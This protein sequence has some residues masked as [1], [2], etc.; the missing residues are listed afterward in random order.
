[1]SADD[2]TI[3]LLQQLVES[4][5]D[6]WQARA[7]LIELHRARGDAQ[8]AYALVADIRPPADL[9]A[10]LLVADVVR[11]V[12]PIRAL[13]HYR[14]IIE[15]ERGCAPAHFALAELHR[16]ADRRE[17]ARHHYSLAVV[18]DAALEDPAFDA[19]LDGE[20]TPASGIPDIYRVEDE[21]DVSQADGDEPDGAGPD[22]E[23]YDDGYDDGEDE[24]D[25]PSSDELQEMID[26]RG[27]AAPRLP[28]IDFRAV[29]GMDEL[30]ERV[31]MH[32]IYP[33]QNPE[34]F[35]KF[36]KRP[37]GGIMLYGP[38]GCGK[39]YLARATAG[40]CNAKFISVT[41][42]D[43]LS[44]WLG[45]SEQRLS[46]IFETARRNAPA[47]IFIDELDALGMNRRD[48]RGSAL[49]TTINHFL[50]EMDGLHASNENLM[51][52]AA[53]N[54]PWSV[55][56]AFRRPGRFDR[57]VL[58]P[59][60]DAAAR[61]AILEIHLREI[62]HEAPDYD[63]LVKATRQFSGADLRAVVERAAEMAIMHEMKTGQP[64]QL[65]RKMLA[66]A[67]KSLKASTVEWLD[68]AKNYANYSNRAGQY[69]DLATY[70]ESKPD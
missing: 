62:P 57:V 12:D 56:P 50:T 55:D 13:E 41:V 69:D 16:S 67:V 54:A 66:K 25:A 53:T 52:L 18:I 23:G 28:K 15:S 11:A 8:A 38:P 30:K 40:E 64:A 6:N 4:Q 27:M 36:K 1:V 3:A 34:L 45:E 32:V 19:W 31:R 68:T 2:T 33:F 51:V 58:V 43:V 29:G 5:P 59:P 9:A 24:D 26:V 46:E 39:T 14:Q 37:G 65:T 44:R 35:K 7:H 49:T 47:V 61:K 17:E 20:T 63:K 42:A 22:E 48:A 21:Q 10:R 60:P 70:L